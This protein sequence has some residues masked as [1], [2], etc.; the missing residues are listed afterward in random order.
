[1][2]NEV[3]R[4][5]EEM[6]TR[7]YLDKMRGVCAARG[8]MID[9]PKTDEFTVCNS[10]QFKNGAMFMCSMILGDVY[11]SNNKHNMYGIPPR[12]WTEEQA[13]LIMEIWHD[14]VELIIMA[15]KEAED[16]ERDN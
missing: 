13:D 6:R 11:R 12:D 9:P 15:V 4:I 2:E 16:A 8:L 14:P 3:V 7:D 10:C 1:M 5:P